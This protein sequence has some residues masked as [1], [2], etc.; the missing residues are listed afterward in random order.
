RRTPD[1]RPAAD[2][3]RAPRSGGTTARAMRLLLAEALRELRSELLIGVD[4]LRLRDELLLGLDVFRIGHATVHRTHRRALFLVEEPDAFRA[5]LGNDVVDVL[6]QRG[7]RP[8]VL[9]GGAALVDG[10]VRT[11]GLAGAAV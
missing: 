10:R 11:L 4:H 5:L 9:E 1:G 2:T 8:V 3:P 7:V 6:R